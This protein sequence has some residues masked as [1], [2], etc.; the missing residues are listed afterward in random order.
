MKKIYPLTIAISIT[1]VA[2][3]IF[4]FAKHTVD[5]LP[6]NK[7]SSSTEAPSG[8]AESTSLNYKEIPRVVHHECTDSNCNHHH[9][10]NTD[11]IIAEQNRK[12]WP[13]IVIEHLEKTYPT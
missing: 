6:Q 3:H 1:A 10:T 5:F 2:W 9:K 7:P 4:G 12:T 11:R 13:H 8:S